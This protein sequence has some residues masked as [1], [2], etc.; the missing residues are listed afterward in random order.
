MSVLKTPMHRLCREAQLLGCA[1]TFI[2]DLLSMKCG[3]LSNVFRLGNNF[4]DP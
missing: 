3:R 1:A 2:P 4:L